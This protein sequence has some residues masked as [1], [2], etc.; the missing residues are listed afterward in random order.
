MNPSTNLSDRS[1]NLV[2]S[3]KGYDPRV[4]L[5]YFI[6]AALLLLLVGGLSY[7]QLFRTEAH[8]KRERHQNLRRVLVPGPR[9]DI[10][11]REGRLLVGNRSR[12]SVVLYLDELRAEIQ[13]EYKLIRI[14]YRA[15][16][17]KDL[18]DETQMTQI[19]R[20]TV[21]QRYLDQVARVL[22]REIRVEPESL[23]KH[24]KEDLLLP[25]T[26]LHDL[27][28][29]EYARLIERLPVRSPLQLY[30]SST[31]FYPFGSAAAHTLGYVGRNENIQAEDFPGKELRT[32]KL[33]GS[34]GRD[35]LEQ[36][37]NADLEG[38]SG[39]QIF[40]VDPSGYRVDS[41]E[42]PKKRPVQGKSLETSLDIDLQRAAEE[43]IGDQ[44]AAAVALDVR[45]GEVL[46]L[47]SKPDYNLAD[48]SPKFTTAARDDIEARNAWTNQAIGGTWAPGSTF[49]ILV[50]MAGLRSGAITPTE[51]IANCQGVVIIGGKEFVCDNRHGMHGRVL[52][53][54]A[55]A[56]SC[57]IYFFAAG[58][59]T[60]AEVVAAEARR[61]HLD[62]RTGIEL[63]NE[64]GRML[65]PDLAWKR[66]KRNEAWYPGDTANMSIGQGDVL[67]SPL[68]MACFAASVARDEV[69]TQPTLVHLP[70]R[71]TQHTEP[72]GLTPVQRAA[73][74][75]GMEAVT[76]YGTGK[77]LS[78]P[79]YRIPGVRVAAKTGTAQKDVTIGGKKGK[80]NLAWFICFAP[81]EKP[82]IAIAVMIEGDK[83]GETFGGGAN[84]GP[85]A[86]TILKKYFEKKNRPTP[87]ILKTAAQ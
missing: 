20:V 45:T 26:L 4:I 42:L 14:A 86:G 35:G 9:G 24:F 10:L 68:Q 18:P 43:A 71:P 47:A 70:D 17:D 73:L 69:F 57:D 29:E 48:L 58:D 6:V 78:S 37:F 87:T 2:E 16:G 59:R 84:A 63:P 40:L 81:I 82:E 54:D 22:K 3:Y 75:E 12:F 32:S 46:V 36:T 19:A 72:I 1:G 38:E 49:K 33:K 80:I 66:A 41:P 85:V 25:Y 61:F 53:K 7:Q 56:H 77:V 44:L 74:L 62:R 39:G 23:Q 21:T 11:D 30:T 60:G 27:E 50:T 52:L 64:V 5:F 13:K 34:M 31:R 83:L 15:T 79:A 51:S 76:T 67:V 55:I 28:Q 8:N 65:I